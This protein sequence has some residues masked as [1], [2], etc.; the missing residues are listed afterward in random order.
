MFSIRNTKLQN[1][2]QCPFLNISKSYGLLNLMYVGKI[3]KRSSWYCCFH[4]QLSISIYSLTLP[5]SIA[6]F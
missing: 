3:I 1:K 4:L 2:N 5:N 6:Y